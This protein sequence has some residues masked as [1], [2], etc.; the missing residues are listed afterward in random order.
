MS[1]TL[2]AWNAPNGQAQLTCRGMAILVGV[3]VEQME[4]VWKPHH[5]TEPDAALQLWLYEGDDV[6]PIH[7]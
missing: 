1:R 5:R 2:L 3:P 7:G 4:K 6:E